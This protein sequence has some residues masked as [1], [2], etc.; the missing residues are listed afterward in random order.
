MLTATDTSRTAAARSTP[1][2]LICFSFSQFVLG[3]LL[4]RKRCYGIRLC[5]M[6]LG[7]TRW[8]SSP[9]HLRQHHVV[10]ERDPAQEKRHGR[11]DESHHRSPLMLVKP[12]RHE[13]PNLVQHHRHRNHDADVKAQADVE[14]DG[15]CGTRIV[16]PVLQVVRAQGRKDRLDNKVD[17]MVGN[18][19]ADHH[20]NANCGDGGNQALAK[21]DQ[22]LEKR[23]APAGVVFG[24]RRKRG[25][26]LG[27][28]RHRSLSR[29]WTLSRARCR[30]DGLRSNQ[31][32]LIQNRLNA[33]PASTQPARFAPSS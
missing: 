21:L 24:V 18:E 17:G 31:Y 9:N 16:E 13:K 25:V 27:T 5:E 3:F 6:T 15:C 19:E 10:A 33:D 28:C 14:A 1:M 30:S 23:H 12:R 11:Y 20:P 2:R 22:M 8:F 32:W 26:R 7:L 29:N 4:A